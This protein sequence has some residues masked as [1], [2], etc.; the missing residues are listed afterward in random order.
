[1]IVVTAAATTATPYVFPA[2]TTTTEWNGYYCSTQT[3][4][5]PNLPT[6]ARGNC[7]VILIVAPNAAAVKAESVGSVR[8]MGLIMGLQ[9]LGALALVLR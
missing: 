7:G 8:L 2:T 3:A 6:T 1:M 4:E 9:G 5:G